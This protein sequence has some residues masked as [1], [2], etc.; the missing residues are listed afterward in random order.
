MTNLVT[1]VF[2][3]GSVRNLA[4]GRQKNDTILL[5]ISSLLVV[6]FG[7]FIA[8]DHSL[9]SKKPIPS[10]RNGLFCKKL[11]GFPV[12]SSTDPPV[13]LPQLSEA[14]FRSISLPS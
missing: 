9:L 3:L 2:T 14:S 11:G 4:A 8:S 12:C 10:G 5:H 7:L 1:P 6:L 13:S